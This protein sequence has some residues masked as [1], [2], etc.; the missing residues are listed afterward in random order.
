M[1][2][3]GKPRL[4]VGLVVGLALL[5]FIASAQITT[6]TVSGTVKDAQGSVVPGATVVLISDTRGVRGEETVTDGR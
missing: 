6:A 3:R 1:Q 5:P 2:S 4:I